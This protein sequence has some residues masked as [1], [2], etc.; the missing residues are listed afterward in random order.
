MLMHE[1]HDRTAR[2]THL[3]KI[4]H[5]YNGCLLIGPDFVTADPML[6]QEGSAILRKV[7]RSTGFLRQ[8]QHLLSP[9]AI[10][11]RLLGEGS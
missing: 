7:T 6:F 3:Q 1:G 4:C 10:A 9:S 8:A 5:G 2:D 11:Q